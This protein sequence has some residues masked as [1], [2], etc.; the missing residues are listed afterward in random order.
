MRDR[1]SVLQG[2][3]VLASLPGLSL[4]DDAQDI[5]PAVGEDPEGSFFEEPAMAHPMG[6]SSQSDVFPAV[7]EDPEAWDA[8]G[9]GSSSAHEAA[10]G[11]ASNAGNCETTAAT[12]TENNTTATID[13]TNAVP[14]R[15]C[16][17]KTSVKQL[18]L[19]N[20]IRVAYNTPP[21]DPARK[22][23][24]AV[25]AKAL[26]TRGD[27]LS[28]SVYFRYHRNMGHTPPRITSVRTQ[29]RKRLLQDNNIPT[30]NLQDTR[31][32]LVQDKSIQHKK[33][34]QEHPQ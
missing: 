8:D 32:F 6:F 30:E 29:H 26:V 13:P 3:P 12:E 31:V 24:A 16:R 17:T 23:I 10:N 15:R 5:F 19:E 22:R 27:L 34:K 18:Q 1:A 20:N 2:E 7:G 33:A 21:A 28:T 4:P 14:R 25:Q 9:P 11:V